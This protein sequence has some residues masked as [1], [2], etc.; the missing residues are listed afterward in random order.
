MPEWAVC[1]VMAEGDPL[2]AREIFE[3]LPETWYAYWLAWKTEVN[4]AQKR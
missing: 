4:R 3:S 2:K 1:L